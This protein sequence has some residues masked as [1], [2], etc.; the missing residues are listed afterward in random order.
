MRSVFTVINNSGRAIGLLGINFNMN[1]PLSEFISTFSLFNNCEK[2]VQP[3]DGKAGSNSI[4]DLVKN[5]V[6]DVVNEISTNVNIPNHDKNKYIVFGLHEKGIF[7]IKGAV[8]MVAE[9]LDLS[10]FTIY[11]YIRE[12]R[13]KA[14]SKK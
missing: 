14:A 10:K 12:M 2:T 4:D 1:T 6:S 8:V 11:S 9:E 3:S 5:A 7:D 13:D